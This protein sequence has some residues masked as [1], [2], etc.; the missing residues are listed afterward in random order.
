MSPTDVAANERAVPVFVDHRVSYVLSEGEDYAYTIRSG[1]TLDVRLRRDDGGWTALEV[2][3]GI[4]GHGD[5]VLEAMRDFQAAIVE[6]LDVLERR[7][8]L[9]DELAWQLDYL[10]ARVRR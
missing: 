10:R 9:S 1:P 7:P 6:H 5:D 4:F 2:E 3:T 8:A